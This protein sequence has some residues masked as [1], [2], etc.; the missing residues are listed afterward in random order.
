MT[1]RVPHPARVDIGV[2]E[3]VLVPVPQFDPRGVELRCTP[4]GVDRCSVGRHPLE[5]VDDELESDVGTAVDRPDPAVRGLY[6]DC[7]TPTQGQRRLDF[8][9]LFF[10]LL[11]CFVDDGVWVRGIYAAPVWVWVRES[12]AGP[13]QCR[14]ARR[15][16]ARLL[17][18][19]Q[20]RSV[21][22]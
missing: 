4:Q 10:F 6:R 16:A 15:T 18:G 14:R 9:T 1:A 7:P 2:S 3:R 17:H 11:F 19:L 12:V 20:I 8:E 22:R 5:W 21:D 13:A